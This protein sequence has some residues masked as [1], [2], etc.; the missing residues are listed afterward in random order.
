MPTKTV[1]KKVITPKLDALQASVP[2]SELLTVQVGDREFKVKALL[3]WP[4][5]SLDHLQNANYKPWFADAVVDG[6][7]LWAERTPTVREIL[8]LI[9]ALDVEQ[10]MAGLSLGK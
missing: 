6:A 9:Q 5:D 4:A 10:L 3:D 8:Q 7:K 2:D 1:A